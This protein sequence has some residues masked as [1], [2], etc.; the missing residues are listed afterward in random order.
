MGKDAR[1][2]RAPVPLTELNQLRPF[3]RWLLFHAPLYYQLHRVFFLG[4][5]VLWLARAPKLAWV[6]YWH[7]RSALREMRKNKPFTVIDGQRIEE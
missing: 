7:D 6:H 2:K 1:R 4:Y 5:L 3:D